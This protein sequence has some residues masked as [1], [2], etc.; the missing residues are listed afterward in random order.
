M[1][2]STVSPGDWK[3]S[4]DAYN[5]TIKCLEGEGIDTGRKTIGVGE[6]EEKIEWN[7]DDA[8]SKIVPSL[9]D[10]EKAEQALKIIDEI[11]LNKIILQSFYEIS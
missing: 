5:E 6:D 11:V 1:T 2:T 8:L 4:P 7:A 3:L 10:S 9:I